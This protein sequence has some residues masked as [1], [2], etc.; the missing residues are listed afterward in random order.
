LKSFLSRTFD[1]V[2]PLLSLL[3]ALVVAS[4]LLIALNTDP[5]QAFASMLQGAFGTENATAET[6]V[7]AIPILFVGIGICVAFRGGVINIG[8]EGQMIA[9]AIGGT[10]ITLLMKDSPGILIIVAALTTGFLAGA[11][12]GGLAGFLKAYFNVNEIL[13]TIML[14]QVAVQ[15]MNFLLN[16]PLLDPAEVGLNHVPKTARIAEQAELPRLSITIP[17][18]FHGLLQGLGFT[19][20]P[21]IFARTRLHY[22]LVLAIILAILTYIL[23]WRTTIGYRIRAVGENERAA[24]YAGIHVKRNMMLAMFLAGGFAGLA[25]VVQ[26][27]GLQYRLQTDGS[28]AGFTANAGFNGIVAALFGGLNPV[29]AVPASIFF[30]G[31]LVGAQKMQRDL[32][33][34]ASLITVIN[35]TIVIFVVSSQLFVKRRARRRLQDGASAEVMPEA[36]PT[37]A[38]VEQQL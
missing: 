18:V 15:M 24:R 16:G 33:V 30:G 27:L 10:T 23:L 4:V 38:A 34:A 5:G 14:N 32:G 35:G 17:Q 26:V 2:P 36:R 13:S 11:L 20:D 1:L 25:G 29:G 12:Y 19:G 22:G 6:L 28:P 9:G 37:P 3:A 21:E 7:K 31:L 8:G